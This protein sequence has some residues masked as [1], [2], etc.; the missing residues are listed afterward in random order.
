MNKR[1]L[2]MFLLGCL[3]VA[4]VA[5]AAVSYKMRVYEIVHSRAG[6][7]LTRMENQ[8]V[9]CYIYK[10]GSNPTMECAWKE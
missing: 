6:R 8:E 1:L 5:Q 3:A 10:A 4:G 7:S 2:G 9:V